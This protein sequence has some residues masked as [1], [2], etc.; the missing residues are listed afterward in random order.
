MTNLEHLRNN[1][2]SLSVEIINQKKNYQNMA[3]LS[4]GKTNSKEETILKKLPTYHNNQIEDENNDFHSV[5]SAPHYS[6][7]SKITWY[8]TGKLGVGR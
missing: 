5:G 6:K 3:D 7:F 4:S 1:M 2:N 8:K